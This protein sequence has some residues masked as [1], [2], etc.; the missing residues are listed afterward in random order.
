MPT[1]GHAPGARREASRYSTIV[2]YL[3][4]AKAGTPPSNGADVLR[5]LVSVLNDLGLWDFTFEEF[6]VRWQGG[7]T[8]RLQELRNKRTE[9]HAQQQKR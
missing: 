9:A 2:S 1:T 8:S 6:C 7:D 5:R 3:V 4:P